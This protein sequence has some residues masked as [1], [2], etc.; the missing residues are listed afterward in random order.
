MLFTPVTMQASRGHMGFGC[1]LRRRQDILDRELRRRPDIQHVLDMSNAPTF[2]TT[3]E[4][5]IRKAVKSGK[6]QGGPKDQHSKESLSWFFEQAVE[7]AKQATSAQMQIYEKLYTEEERLKIAVVEHARRCEYLLVGACATHVT[8]Y[9]Q[10]WN[11]D[12]N[13]SLNMQTVSIWHLLGHKGHLHP[14]GRPPRALPAPARQRHH[15]Q[16]IAILQH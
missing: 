6:K 11:R 8:S 2:K 13:A 4:A 5:A 16:T 7:A 12:V 14:F 15:G 9:L 1:G 10:I 3:D